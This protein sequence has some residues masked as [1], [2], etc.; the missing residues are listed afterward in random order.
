[1]QHHFFREFFAR[2][3]ASVVHVASKFSTQT[4]WQSHCRRSLPGFTEN[5]LWVCCGDFAIVV[6]YLFCLDSP[7]SSVRSEVIPG[8]A[9]RTFTKRLFVVYRCVL[10]AISGV[11]RGR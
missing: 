3:E 2:E 4:L 9:L 6:F 8:T 11:G 7:L 5:L 10:K 1:M